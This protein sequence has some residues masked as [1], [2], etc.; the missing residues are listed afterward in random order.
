MLYADEGGV[1]PGNKVKVRSG[2][3]ETLNKLIS[4]QIG[5]RLDEGD[6]VI[7]GEGAVIV[8]TYKEPAHKK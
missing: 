1:P 7:L 2:T 4:T 8:F 5:H 6:Q 3:S